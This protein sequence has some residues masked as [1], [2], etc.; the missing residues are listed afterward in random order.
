M[1]GSVELTAVDVNLVD[2][3]L[4]LAPDLRLLLDSLTASVANAAPDTTSGASNATQLT[5]DVQLSGLRLHASGH[6]SCAVTRAVLSVSTAG[7]NSEVRSVVL[8]LAT[9][10]VCI[11]V[12][13][14]APDGYLDLLRWGRHLRACTAAAIHATHVM[15]ET[16][17]RKQTLSRANS[18]ASAEVEVAAADGDELPR[19]L[20]VLQMSMLSVQVAAKLSVS[21]IFARLSDV[22]SMASHSTVL[23]LSLGKVALSAERGHSANSAVGLTAELDG[24]R[25]C[26]VCEAYALNCE[27]VPGRLLVWHKLIADT[28]VEPRPDAA[29]FAIDARAQATGLLGNVLV[30]Y[31]LRSRRCSRPASQPGGSVGQAAAVETVIACFAAAR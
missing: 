28:T 30:P 19:P 16:L 13:A 29:L 27:H 10:S 18:I 31:S 7:A 9:E 21:R 4:P 8:D 1:T 14:A 22:A 11:D 6:E 5:A 17:M 24:A 20:R 12:A 26:T 23:G 25:V 2:D 15:T 3:T